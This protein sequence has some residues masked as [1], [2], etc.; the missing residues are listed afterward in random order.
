MRTSP[1]ELI[2]VTYADKSSSS[3][4][5]AMITSRGRMAPLGNKTTH[6]AKRRRRWRFAS[7]SKVL[8]EIR[9]Y[10]N[11]T[12]NL[13]PRASFGRLVRQLTYQISD[14]IRWKGEGLLALQEAAEAFLVRV[15]ED[16][17]MC[18]RHSKRVTVM[19]RDIALTARLRLKAPIAE[20]HY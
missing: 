6:G 7:G 5:G 20:V 14:K 13:I 12:A 19:Q 1:P 3:P 2:R 10:Q 15:L 11:S 17:N 4:A 18:A 9:R 16:A 8:S